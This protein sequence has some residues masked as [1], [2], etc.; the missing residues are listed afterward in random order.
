M[1]LI[2]EIQPMPWSS[3]LLEC[4]FYLFFVGLLHCV[5]FIVAYIGLFIFSA[6]SRKQSGFLTRRIGRFT[7]FNVLLLFVGS[8]F[9]GVWSC[10]IW[11]RFYYSHDY[12]VDFT[13][14]W[15]TTQSDIDYGCG[16]VHGELYGISLI[17][18]QL[19]WLLFAVGTWATSIYL[20]RLIQRRRSA[21][22]TTDHGQLT[23]D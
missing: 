3:F 13:P 2:A 11:G 12:L 4:E 17:E 8:V 22:P 1:E 21:L 16:D 23:T 9:N 19:I 18:L 15:P 6:L 7:L 5:G 14:F 20:Y 10:T